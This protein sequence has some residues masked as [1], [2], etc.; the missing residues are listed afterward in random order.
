MWKN[1]FSSQSI[2]KQVTGW[3]EFADREHKGSIHFSCKWDTHEISLLWSPS[4]SFLRILW[5]C[6]TL[7]LLPLFNLLFP[8]SIMVYP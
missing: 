8:F 7:C 1:T 5:I 3:S 6:D 4:P 2:H